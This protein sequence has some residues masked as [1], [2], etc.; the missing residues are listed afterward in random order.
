MKCYNGD[1]TLRR[2]SSS[3][4]RRKG[5]CWCLPGLLESF[6][7]SDSIL[8]SPAVLPTSSE[9][10]AKPRTPFL[11]LPREVGP[12]LVDEQ[13]KGTRMPTG[14][15]SQTSQWTPHNPQHSSTCT[16]FLGRQRYCACPVFGGR[17]WFRRLDSFG[18]KVLTAPH[19]ISVSNELEY[20]CWVEKIES[21]TRN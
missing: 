9:T 6:T 19:K 12:H 15:T 5:G 4:R 2:K 16:P 7:V 1:E 3:L 14:S 20:T 11:T 21:K 8:N 18:Y 10:L 13:L 17:Q